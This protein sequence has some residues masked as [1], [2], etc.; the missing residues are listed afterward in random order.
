MVCKR[1]GCKFDSKKYMLRNGSVR[2]PD[3]KATY[4]KKHSHNAYGNT[5]VETFSKA[6]TRAKGKTFLH[7]VCWAVSLCFLGIVFLLTIRVV[8]TNAE[9]EK[10]SQHT[11]TTQ[12]D[13]TTQMQ[14]VYRRE[15][16]FSIDG[17]DLTAY[18]TGALVDNKPYGEGIY[19]FDDTHGSWSFVGTLENGIF[20][21]GTMTDYPYAMTLDDNQSYSKYT[22]AFSNGQPSGN[23][24]YTIISGENTTVLEGEYDAENGFTGNVS[25]FP[26]SF[27]YNGI[28]FNGMYSGGYLNGQPNGEGSFL[29][30][31]DTFFN[32]DG[33]W[34]NG[35]IYGPGQLN[36]NNARMNINGSLVRAEYN[37]HIEYGCFNGEGTIAVHQNDMNYVYS[38][39]WL[40]NTYSGEGSLSVS[41]KEGIGYT[42]DGFW[43]EGL[44]DGEGALVYN[45]D[46]IV[47][48]IGNFEKGDFRPTIPQ[49]IT[50]LCSAENSKVALAD[51]TL[52]YIA[53]Y[54][55]AFIEHLG[56]DCNYEFSY[57]AYVENQNEMTASVFS[58]SIKVLQTKTYDDEVFGYPVTE[59][60]GYDE[61]SN[62]YYGYYIGKFDDIKSGDT[63]NIVAYPIGYASYKTQSSED[64]TALRFVAFSVDKL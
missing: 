63:A 58:K 23:G 64:A 13:V 33:T 46:D 27:A 11:S 55:D 48:Y 42:Y 29:S 8:N 62:I 16:C 3:C 52:Q 6:S 20:F 15:L 24:V 22:G 41:S 35:S 18:Y 12:T 31:G 54:Q 32:Y 47:K 56:V 25:Q 39:N 44:Y 34:D 60:V 45:N 59:F 53:K 36:T 4:R 10:I 14:L 30:N 26:M 57:E 5:T 51:Y 37:G 43:Q 9:T 17:N 2:C 50:C 1:C 40:N 7:R 38:G 21:N 19:Q 49:L 61:N 28:T